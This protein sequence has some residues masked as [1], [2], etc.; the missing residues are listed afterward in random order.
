M[1]ALTPLATATACESPQHRFV[2]ADSLLGPA[3]E[4]LA[5]DLAT[6]Q[7]SDLKR[8]EAPLSFTVPAGRRL[9]GF[10]SWFECEFG[11][12]GWL[13]S[14]SPTSAATHWRQTAFYLKQSMEGG[15]G[16]VTVEGK[17]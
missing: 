9:D 2:P 8:F 1:S 11:E 12:A 4:I 13:L 3:I 15:G 14:T 6:V 5:I 10:V 17:V 16:G 7:Q